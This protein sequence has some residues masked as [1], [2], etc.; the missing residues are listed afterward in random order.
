MREASTLFAVPA[1]VPGPDEPCFLVKMHGA[2]LFWNE[3]ERLW[4]R[5]DRATQ[6]NENAAYIRARVIKPWVCDVVRGR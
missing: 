2:D 5:V 6:F 4:V 1:H 3:E